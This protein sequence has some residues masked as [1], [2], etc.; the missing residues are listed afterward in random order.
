[1]GVTALS[2]I[3]KRYC[4]HG[5]VT[6]KFLL[7]TIRRLTIKIVL[8]ATKNNHCSDIWF[9]YVFLDFIKKSVGS[10]LNKSHMYNRKTGNLRTFQGLANFQVLSRLGLF[11]Q[12]Q[13][14]F[15]IFKDRWNSSLEIIF[16]AD[17]HFAANFVSAPDKI[18]GYFFFSYAWELAIFN[19]FR[20]LNE[21]TVDSLGVHDIHSKIAKR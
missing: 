11:F 4:C 1:M 10:Y 16:S 8:I 6:Y 5:N 2:T 9:N 17:G 18:S 7:T 21:S 12:T 13:G 15:R 3:L 20:I 19:V 14:P